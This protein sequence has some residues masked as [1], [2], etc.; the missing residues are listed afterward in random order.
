ML[1]VL[2][3]EGKFLQLSLG[4]S[5]ISPWAQNFLNVNVEE[6]QARSKSDLAKSDIEYFDPGDRNE[7]SAHIEKYFWSPMSVAIGLDNNL[8]VTESNRHRIQVFSIND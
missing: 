5:G 1:Q 4:E 2:D 3:S 7:I 6:G 8:Y